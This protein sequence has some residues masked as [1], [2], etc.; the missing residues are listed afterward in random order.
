MFYPRLRTIVRS[1]LNG[2]PVVL[3]FSGLRACAKRLAGAKRWSPSCQRL[4]D[5]IV[6]YLRHCL[7]SEPNREGCTLVVE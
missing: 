1:R 3:R 5:Q 7:S 4:Q 6:E 2:E